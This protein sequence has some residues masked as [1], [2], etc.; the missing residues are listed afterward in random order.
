MYKKKFKAEHEEFWGSCKVL[1]IEDDEED[2]RVSGYI[3]GNLLKHKEVGTFSELLGCHFSSFAS[4]V[5]KYG[6]DFMREL[7]YDVIDIDEDAEGI[8]DMKKFKIG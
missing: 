3:A 7:V 8:V 1:K 6:E 2:Q 5:E 4:M